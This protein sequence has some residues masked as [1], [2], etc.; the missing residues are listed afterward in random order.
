MKFKLLIHAKYQSLS[1]PLSKRETM[2]LAIIDLGT[3]TCNLLITEL[4]EGNYTVLHEAKLG[5]KLGKSGIHKNELTIDAFERAKSA[6]KQHIKTIKKF[7]PDEMVALATSAV[8]DA[9]NRDQFK[10]FIFEKTGLQLQVISGDDEARLIYQGVKLALQNISS[11]SIILDIG[12]G[13]NE[14]IIPNKT[15]IQWKESFPLGMSR[16]LELFH[17]SDPI[18]PEEIIRIENYFK[19]GLE[20]LWKETSS[21]TINQLIGCSGAFDTICDLIDQTEP[22]TKKRIKQE[23]SLN[24]FKTVCAEVIQSTKAQRK[25]MVG[26]EALRIEMIVPSIIFIRL[27]AQKLKLSSIIQTDFALREGVLFDRIND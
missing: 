22:G 4:D 13:S 12:G 16:V 23:I 27:V 3:N 9:E 10:H 5:V 24:D 2:R 8:R 11:N 7:K 1:L 19:Q 6:L 15:G 20:N 14:F 17:I 26:M 18:L 21:K 25:Q